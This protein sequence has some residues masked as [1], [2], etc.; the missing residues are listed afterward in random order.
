MS[1]WL[2]R[3]LNRSSAF[4]RPH[5]RRAERSDCC[6]MKIT[7]PKLSLPRPAMSWLA[8]PVTIVISTAAAAQDNRRPLKPPQIA[9]VTI[10]AGAKAYSRFPGA[11]EVGIQHMLIFQSRREGQPLPLIAPDQNFGLR[12]VRLRGVRS[13]LALKLQG[14][15]REKD[16]GAAVGNVAR[17][18]EVGGFLEAFASKSLRIRTEVRQGINGHNGLAGDLGADLFVRPDHLSTFSIGPRVR[19]ADRNYINAYYGVTPATAAR[20]GIDVFEPSGGIHSVGA[21]AG[22]RLNVGRGV[23]VHSYGRYDRLINDAADSPIV[24]RFGSR[25]QFRAGLGLSFSLKV[26]VPAAPAP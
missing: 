5:S 23:A 24:A 25:D 19:W 13:G 7:P 9:I 1:K 4:P 2:A 11:K 8:L 15:R 26:R 10:G 16:V 12:L 17:T 18:L 20:T 21:T 3:Y 22:I 6:G 14:R